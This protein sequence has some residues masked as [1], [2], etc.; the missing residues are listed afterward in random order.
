[1][2][3]KY[4]RKAFLAD[5]PLDVSHVG[6]YIIAQMVSKLFIF[7]QSWAV[8]HFKINHYLEIPLNM[9]VLVIYG[10]IKP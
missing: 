5:L 9:N 1:M 7:L 6:V 4:V 3:L 10:I 2:H 8:A